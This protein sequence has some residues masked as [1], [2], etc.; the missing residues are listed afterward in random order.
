[1]SGVVFVGSKGDGSKDP[2][3]RQGREAQNG[4]GKVG[5]EMEKER[6]T[7]WGW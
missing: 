4:E 5:R 1:M 2:E 7:Q 6:E 3:R